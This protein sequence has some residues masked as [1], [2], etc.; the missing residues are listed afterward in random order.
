MNSKRSSRPT[1]IPGTT[2]S[3]LLAYRWNR[4]ANRDSMDRI[5]PFAGVIN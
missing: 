3:L 2:S 4:L 5:R 1:G